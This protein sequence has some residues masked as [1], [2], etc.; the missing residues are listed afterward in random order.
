MNPSPFGHAVKRLLDIA[1]C[2]AS[3]PIVMPLGAA[4]AVAVKLTSPGPVLYRANRIGRDMRPISVWKF[5]TMRADCGGPSITR[6]GDPRITPFGHWLRDSKLDELPQVLNVLKGDMSLVG[7]RPEDPRYVASYSPEQRR[8][9]SMRPGITSLAFLRFGHE[10]ELIERAGA[11][12]PET[13]YLTEILPEKLAIEL[14]Y[15]RNWTMRGDLRILA[16]T[17]GG[18][19]SESATTA[20]SPVPH[21]EFR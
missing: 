15:V 8:V 14:R 21:H 2:I 13:Y 1:L 9:L 4:I 10:Q 17:V 3:L 6:T 11:S 5:R 16:R 12:D 20:V 19:F 7:P 18:L